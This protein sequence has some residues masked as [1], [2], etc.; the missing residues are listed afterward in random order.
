MHE[1]RSVA[2]TA[3]AVGFSLWGDMALYVILPLHGPQLGLTAVQIG[4]LLSVNRWIR[5]ISNHIARAALESSVS[6]RLFAAALVAGSFTTAVYAAE[7]RFVLFLAARAGW[8][9][10]WSFIRHAGVQHTVAAGPLDAAGTRIGLYDAVIQAAFV[11]GTMAAGLSYDRYGYGATFV[12]AA[13]LSLPAALLAAWGR[14]AGAAASVAAPAGQ[15]GA[16]SRAGG[17]A[18]AAGGIPGVA[19]SAA[20]EIALLARGFAVT[21]VGT[22]LII[23]TIGY[24]LRSRLEAASDLGFLAGALIATHYAINGIGSPFLG[25]LVDRV[26]GPRVQTAGFGVGTAALLVATRA[27]S[28]ALLV[29][30]VVLFFIAT[31]ACRIALVTHAAGRSSVHLSRLMTAF[32]TGAASGPVVGWVAIQ[33]IGSPEIVFV[34]GALLFAA[35]ALVHRNTI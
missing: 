16:E 15:R 4:L 30:A 20:H 22:G 14:R 3:S 1:H 5:L 23:S 31:V 11:V 32:D 8:G 9:V 24:V 27:A 13:I 33:W 10:C 29:A 6:A 35:A 25:L 34:I 2:V 28:P 21:A 17:G 12:A 7:P 18:G 26:G 19:P